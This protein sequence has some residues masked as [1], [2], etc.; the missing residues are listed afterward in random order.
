MSY[1]LRLPPKS[2]VSLTC[3][4]D[5]GFPHFRSRSVAL[6]GSLGTYVGLVNDVQ[7]PH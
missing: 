7:S 1:E 3:S 4:G 5:V 2:A 6:D